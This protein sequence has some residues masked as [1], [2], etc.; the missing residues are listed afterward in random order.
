MPSSAV[1]GFG[2]LLQ[3]GDGATPT[4]NFTTIAEVKS[5]SGPSLSADTIDVTNMSS[6]NGWREFIQGPKDGGEV[7]FDVNFLPT[8]ATH[9][10]A[11]GL[12]R[13]FKNGTRRNFKLVFPNPG[14]TTWQFAAIVT[15]FEVSAPVDDVLGASI[16]LKLTGEPVLA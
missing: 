8:N 9:N 1:S 7:T 12:L 11:T 6:P 15:G 10:A 14:N 16:T 13:D 5:I 2:T 3:I 4:E